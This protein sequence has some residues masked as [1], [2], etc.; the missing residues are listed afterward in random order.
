MAEHLD[1]EKIRQLAGLMR[2]RGLTKVVL[3]E[4]GVTVRDRKSV[5]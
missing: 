1:I 2:K 3:T 4:D 5:V